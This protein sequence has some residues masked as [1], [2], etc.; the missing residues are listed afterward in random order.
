MIT[1]VNISKFKIIVPAELLSFFLLKKRMV[2]LSLENSVLCKHSPTFCLVLRVYNK[3]D[4][5]CL[6]LFNIGIIHPQQGNIQL[7]FVSLNI[8][9]YG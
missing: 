9:Y 4:I 8:P 5:P 6:F 3:I 2:M 7:R 1:T